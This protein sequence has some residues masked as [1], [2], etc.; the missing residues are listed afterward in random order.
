MRNLSWQAKLVIL[1]TDDTKVRDELL[2]RFS[3]VLKG[4]YLNMTNLT[5]GTPA[6]RREMTCR[7]FKTLMVEATRWGLRK[8]LIIRL[9]RF[10]L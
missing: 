8:L 9:R 5:G 1:V 10:T 6:Y 4:A 7:L 2:G 3:M